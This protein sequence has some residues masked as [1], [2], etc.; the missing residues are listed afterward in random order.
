MLLLKGIHHIPSLIFLSLKMMS[1]I[2]LLSESDDEGS[3]GS[4]NITNVAPINQF[5]C[6]YCHETFKTA[7]DLS[8]H[9]STYT[10]CNI[11]RALLRQQN[12]TPLQTYMPPPPPSSH[13]VLFL[14]RVPGSGNY[15]LH[16]QPYTIRPI[17]E[18]PVFPHTHDHN[19]IDESLGR[20]MDLISLMDK[21]IDSAPKEELPV[22]WRDGSARDI[23][24]DLKL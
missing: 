2:E 23:N 17:P 16:F 22:V 8:W 14:N 12:N 21:P 7:Q 20:T 18:D 4:S 10:I 24:L 3:T 9:Q 15:N 1:D 11:N 5:P 6:N 19:N 13:T